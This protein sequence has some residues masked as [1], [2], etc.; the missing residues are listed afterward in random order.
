VQGERSLV[1]LLDH[2]LTGL[3]VPDLRYRLT[4]HR[5]RRPSGVEYNESTLLGA[6]PEVMLPPHLQELRSVL[7]LP[8]EHHGARS[9]E[10]EYDVG[11]GKDS[12]SDEAEKAPAN[13]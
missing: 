3:A 10:E 11:L 1:H 4:P 8:L 7:L 6:E 12:R 5:I 13:A 2:A 9:I